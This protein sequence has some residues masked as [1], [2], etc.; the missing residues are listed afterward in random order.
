VTDDSAVAVAV[1]VG[2]VELAICNGLNFSLLFLGYARL[3]ML[4]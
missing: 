2:I 1:V 4:A 3:L